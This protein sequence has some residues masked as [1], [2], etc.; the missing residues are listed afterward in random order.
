MLIRELRT[1][2]KVHHKTMDAVFNQLD[3]QSRNEPMTDNFKKCVQLIKLFSRNYFMQ[4]RLKNV[5]DDVAKLNSDLVEFQYLTGIRVSDL[6]IAD[7]PERTSP[8]LKAP[9]NKEPMVFSRR[10]L[11]V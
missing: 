5:Q 8:N 1:P 2:V 11:A 3:I 7:P 9:L 10:K 4:A 6:M